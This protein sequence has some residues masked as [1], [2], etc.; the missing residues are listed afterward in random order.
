MLSAELAL[1][2]SV[3]VVACAHAS[4]QEPF[5]PPSSAVARAFVPPPGAIT[6]KASESWQSDDGELEVEIANVID[7]SNP[8]PPDLR[9][10]WSGIVRQIVI[11]VTHGE[12]TQALRLNE[13]AIR[14]IGSWRIEVLNVTGNEASLMFVRDVE[15]PPKPNVSE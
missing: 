6:L 11:N 8:C 5:L 4:P 7:Y 10:V 13:Q 12:E 2:G 15:T 14:R 9:C 1:V 3:V